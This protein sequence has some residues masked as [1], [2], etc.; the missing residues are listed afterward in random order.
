MTQTIHV[1]RRAHERFPVSWPI[2]LM[3]QEALL[4]GRVVD[5][6]EQ[7]L[8]VLTAPTGALKQ[9]LSCR[10]EMVLSEIQTVTCNAEVRHVTDALVGLRTSE[11]FKF[12]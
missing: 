12:S 4:V 11:R 1:N 10:I 9:G 7:G 2:R 3:L 5:V 6:S 8:C